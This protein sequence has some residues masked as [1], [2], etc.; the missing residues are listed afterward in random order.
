MDDRRRYGLFFHL[1]NGA[2]VVNRHKTPIIR[3]ALHGLNQ[4]P[5]VA[6]IQVVCILSPN[7]RFQTVP[8]PDFRTDIVGERKIARYAM[9]F[10]NKRA[11]NRLHSFSFPSGSYL[12]SSDL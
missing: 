8:H 3:A 11:S 4:F 7:G 2:G 5:A 9:A 12:S 1:A 10:V 6:K